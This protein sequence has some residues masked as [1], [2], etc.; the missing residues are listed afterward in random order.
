MSQLYCYFWMLDTVAYAFN[1]STLEAEA[2]FEASLINR[3]S[4]MTA[5]KYKS[6][7]QCDIPQ[8]F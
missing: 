3:A 4:S 1:S 5:K 7:M 6:I 2:E 8:I